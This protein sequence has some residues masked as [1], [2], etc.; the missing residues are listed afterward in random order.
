[1]NPMPDPIGRSADAPRPFLLLP[2]LGL[3][4]VVCL[5]LWILTCGSCHALPFDGADF[6]SETTIDP[7]CASW[8]ELAILP[9]VGRKTAVGIVA[10]REAARVSAG[11]RVCAS[12]SRRSYFPM[13]DMSAGEQIASGAEFAA[14][15]S[16]GCVFRDAS[17]LEAVLGIGP[18]TAALLAPRLR[19][20]G[21]D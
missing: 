13:E 11:L 21:C 5:S 18:K 20:C 7:N 19:F 17:D 12:G 1:M 9:R 8:A 4:G 15:G 6:R 16:G 2:H 10:Y 14:T 3:A